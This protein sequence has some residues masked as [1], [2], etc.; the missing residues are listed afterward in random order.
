MSGEILYESHTLKII[1]RMLIARQLFG[2]LGSTAKD[3][4]E[5][6]PVQQAQTQPLPGLLDLT[7]FFIPLNFCTS[8]C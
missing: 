4:I 6:T 8:V 1:A 2:F 5:G 7:L 3:R